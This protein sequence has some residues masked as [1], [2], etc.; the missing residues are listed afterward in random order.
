MPS[1]STGDWKASFRVWRSDR[2]HDAA[3]ATARLFVGV[4]TH[5]GSELPTR[6][7]QLHQHVA[8]RMREQAAAVSLAAKRQR[9][10]HA[11]VLP[12]DIKVGDDREAARIVGR[13]GIFEFRATHLRSSSCSAGSDSRA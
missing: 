9:A 8:R 11:A 13:R 4:D 2:E 7:R 10:V 6:P 12:H 1:R 3:L 5:A